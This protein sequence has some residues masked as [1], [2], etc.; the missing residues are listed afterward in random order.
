MIVSLQSYVHRTE[1]VI[2]RWA[3]DPRCHSILRIIA[4]IFAGFCLSAASLGNACLPLA[5]AL[6][7]AC[8][9]WAT[10]LCAV[11]GALGYLFFWA[12]AGY[13]GV[14]WIITGLAAVLLMGEHR[15]S[16]KTP[17]LL[18][19]ALG[20][21]I[22]ASGVI[23]QVILKDQTPIPV[24]L[25]RV[26]LG[27]GSA[28]LF[29][30]VIQGRNPILD[31]MA[32][33]LL[34]LSL[35]QILPI[36]YL[37]LGYIAAGFIA[38][39]GA[40]PA[41]AI[42]GLAL[43]LAQITPVPMTAVMTLGYLVRFLPRYPK[44]LAAT[45]PA[46]VYIAVMSLTGSWD[47]HP[48]PGLLLG[49]I[50][51]VFLPLPKKFA[52]RRGE[53]GVA[54]V[55]LELAASVLT[56]TQMLLM[57]VES[58]PVDEEALVERAAERACSSCAYRK[59]CRDSKRL[60]QI[61]S[62]TLHK[63]LLSTEELP[64]IC[65]KP[66]RVLAELH[67]CQEQLRSIRA[68]R[69]RQKEYR[70]AVVQQYRFLSAFLQDLADQLPRRAEQSRNHFYPEVTVYGNRSEQDNGDRC[71]R[72]AG[73]GKKYYVLLCDG[74][75]QGIGAVTEGRAAASLL[76]RMLAAGYPAEYAL[77]SLNSLCALRERAGAVSVD[78]AE[79]ML[80]SGKVN[81]YK[82]G[83]A[84][85]YLTTRYGAERIG[86]TSPP[87]GLSVLEQE[88][89]ERISLR[90][91]EWLVMVSDGVGQREALRCCMENGDCSPGELAT[92]ILNSRQPEIKEDDATVVVLR[93]SPIN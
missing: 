14:F 62:V 78:L 59:S 16:Q 41:A 55:R 77:R 19:A 71:L 36:P 64:V 30:K 61:P 1:R 39:S 24:Y 74:M 88:K 9:G 28:V 31:W 34:V 35:A 13:I 67:R 7:C 42:S 8:N 87:P 6:S 33:G 76:H 44:T 85:S 58:G 65:R 68:D 32:T 86:T 63:P 90:R 75:G 47:I 18:P 81:L 45:A 83:A 48:L 57:E 2:R 79:V 3:V 91:G 80:D 49:G 10:V 56:Q 84:P 72:F 52:H 21:L 27:A 69:E 53:T 93:L 40:F 5:M 37:G 82:W 89:V 15:L 73:V 60:C 46:V 43:D 54:Q 50:I 51:G 70:A 25:L 66:G 22:A 23:F 11:G 26:V 12:D 20:F 17:L 92:G 38:G 4:Y 29:A